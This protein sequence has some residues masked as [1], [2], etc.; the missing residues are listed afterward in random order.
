[1]PDS[2]ALVKGGA[3]IGDRYF[4]AWEDVGYGEEP[5][6]DMAAFDGSGTLI[7]RTTVS[8]GQASANWPAIAA[9][10]GGLVV[11]YYQFR[12]GFASVYAEGFDTDMTP[13]GDELLLAEGAKYPSVA[14]ARGTMMFAYHSEMAG[15]VVVTAGVCE[16]EGQ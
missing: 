9:A 14:S 16:E 3:S 13:V 1:V 10:D 4:V 2:A 12:E 6:V 8:P 11:A 5:V 7:G 15:E